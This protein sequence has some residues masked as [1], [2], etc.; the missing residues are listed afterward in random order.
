MQFHDA[1]PFLPRSYVDHAKD[2]LDPNEY[3]IFVASRFGIET[4]VRDGKV[5]ANPFAGG[6]PIAY[7][8]S[9]GGTTCARCALQWY[10]SPLIGCGILEEEPEED[11]ETVDWSDEPQF[12]TRCDDCSR[13]I[14]IAIKE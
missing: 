6:H 11:G 7:Y 9:D 14:D 13:P 10:P 2:D 4:W 8:D 3:A 1:L 12:H 5:I